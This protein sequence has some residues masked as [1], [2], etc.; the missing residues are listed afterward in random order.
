MKQSCHCLTQIRSSLVYILAASALMGGATAQAAVSLDRTRAVFNGDNKSVSLNISNENKQIPYLA[1]AW[2]ENASGKKIT[3]GPLVV[4][5]PVQ[6]MEP[7][8][9]SV[10]RIMSTPGVASLP[11]DRESLFYFNLREIPPKSDKPNVLQIA[12]QTRIKLFYR[13]EAIVQAPGAVWQDKL[14]L[15]RQAGGYRIENPTAYYITVIGIG[16]TVEQAEKG[17]F[18]TVMVSPKSSVSVK[19]GT[20]AS[21]YLTYI[22]DYG[23][24]PT[25]RFACSGDRCVSEGKA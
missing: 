20:W 12:L 6:R 2:L 16:G 11:K 9:K 10:V 4:T 21:P 19:S 3:T 22:N 15:H 5:P 17:K 24:R 13:P 7:G 23:G 18:D 8:T 14:V 1:Q 25:L